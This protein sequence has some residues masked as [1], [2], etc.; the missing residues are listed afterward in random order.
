MY[1]GCRMSDIGCVNFYFDYQ[2]NNIITHN[3]NTTP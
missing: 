1:F 2:A 3:Y